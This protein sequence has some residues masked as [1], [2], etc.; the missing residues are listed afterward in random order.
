MLLCGDSSRYSSMDATAPRAAQ[1]PSRS[2]GGTWPATALS[3]APKIGAGRSRMPI[4]MAPSG[5][6]Y[7]TVGNVPRFVGAIAA[8]DGGPAGAPVTQHPAD[9][10]HQGEGAAGAHGRSEEHT[11]ALHSLMR[12][13]Y[14]A[15][16]E[17]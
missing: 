12:N 3:M 9:R 15:L 6:V 16:C 11:S 2:N 5:A 14:A 13:Q 8:V 4:V 7:A 1:R 17:T 10:P